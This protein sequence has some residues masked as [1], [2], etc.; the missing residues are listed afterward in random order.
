MNNCDLDDEKM[1]FCN[2]INSYSRHM[3]LFRHSLTLCKGL[4]RLQTC[5]LGPS[6]SRKI[7]RHRLPLTARLTTSVPNRNA[8]DYAEKKDRILTLPNLLCVSR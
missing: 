2:L 4:N 3:A 7:L 8:D 1:H 6:V 5:T